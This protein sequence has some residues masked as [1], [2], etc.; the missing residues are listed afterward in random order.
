M[1]RIVFM[2]QIQLP[3]AKPFYGPE[4]EQAVARV[5]RSGW[6]TQGPEVAALEREFAD[7]CGARHGV[8][9]ANCTIAL[10]LS[11]V[12]AGIGAGDEVVTVSHSFIATANAVRQAGAVPVFVDVRLDDFNM[13]PAKL[14]AAITLRTKAILAVHQMGMPARIAEIRAV[15]ERRKLILI[16]DAA[17]AVGSEIRTGEGWTRIG[18]PFGLAACFS[19]HPRKLLATGDGGIITTDDD[20]FAAR[21]RLLRQHAMSVNDRARHQSDQVMFE[22]YETVG[23]N[24][25]LT[26]IQAAIGRCQLNRVPA[27]VTE[28]RALAGAYQ[29]ALARI[30]GLVPPQDRADTR[31]NWQSYCVLLPEG[32]DQ[33]G[34]MQRLLD[35]GIS[36]RR[37]VMCIHREPAYA[38]PPESDGVRAPLPVSEEAQDRGVILPMFAGMTADQARWVAGRIDDAL[39][40]APKARAC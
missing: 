34:V 39:A 40:A 2:P 24:Y 36:T 20:D 21:L 33:R 25:R 18:K 30:P 15:A 22:S 3:V 5:L 26:D 35:D 8:A 16:E 13:D 32:A 9:V 29:Q 28:R 31:T 12:A 19:F 23:F 10:H 17:C 27:M 37:G 6:V 11:L 38:N 7:Y 4:E 14:E 1:Q